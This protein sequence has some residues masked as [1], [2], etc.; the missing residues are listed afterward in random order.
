MPVNNMNGKVYK[1]NYETLR[2]ELM[3]L[4]AIFADKQLQMMYIDKWIEVLN[5]ADENTCRSFTEPQNQKM[6]EKEN[7][8]APE[9]FQTV[10]NY[11]SNTLYIHFRVSRMRQILKS[12]DPSGKMSQEISLDEFTKGKQMNWVAT[13]DTVSIKSEPIII[14]PFTIDEAY[15][16][17]VVDGNHRITEAIKKGKKTINAYVLDANWIVQGNLFC[18]EFDKMLYIFQNEMVDIATWIK[19]DGMSD[20]DAIKKS[21]F[22]SDI[23]EL[24]FKSQQL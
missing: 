11:K 9:K 2:D 17:L 19:R 7:L 13:E 20:K 8:E 6:I 24:F 22:V 12:S 1:I 18:S 4:P 10:V 16:M 5:I 14:V 15:K 23:R 3:G 21:Y